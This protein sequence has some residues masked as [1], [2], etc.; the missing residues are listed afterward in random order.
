MVE[1]RWLIN[2]KGVTSQTLQYR[3]QY[4][5]KIEA[6]TLNLGAFVAELATT[7]E[8]QTKWSDWK[9]VP[10]VIDSQMVQSSDKTQNRPY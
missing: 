7:P 2:T 5:P 4:S 8:P 9:D 1:L 10:I 3:Q 6:Q